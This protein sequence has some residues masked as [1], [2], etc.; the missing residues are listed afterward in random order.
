MIHRRGAGSEGIPAGITV[1]SYGGSSYTAPAMTVA[2]TGTETALS[3]FGT[4]LID[5]D[6][7]DL[8]SGSISSWPNRGNTSVMTAI[9]Q[10][11]A[12]NKPTY[13]ATGLN[14]GPA[15][16]FDGSDDYMGPQAYDS[17]HAQPFSEFL[18]IQVSTGNTGTFF[19]DGGDLTHRHAYNTQTGASGCYIYAG[20]AL[21]DTG[22]HISLDVP[23][24]IDT[25]FDTT[26]SDLTIDGTSRATGDVGSQGNNGLVLANDPVLSS[27]A[28]KGF[29]AKYVV[30][31]G[32]LS[33]GNR[34]SV[35]NLI[36][37][38]WGL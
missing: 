11:T 2:A 29:L 37:R 34:T 30:F 8:S 22:D 18:L 15:A 23:H 3:D 32:V 35:R 16:Q 26:T 10:G 24:L 6:A 17:S 7:H 25:V 20:A 21:I 5:L 31:S 27:V 4:V 36:K 33:A 12:A 28:M 38:A 19:V 13:S 9:T 14:G 1:H